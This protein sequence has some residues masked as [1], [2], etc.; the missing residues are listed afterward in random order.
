MVRKVQIRDIQRFTHDPLLLVLRK[1]YFDCPITWDFATMTSCI[2]LS[3]RKSDKIPEGR[4]STYILHLSD[5]N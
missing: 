1:E 5:S 3:V 4:T 2:D